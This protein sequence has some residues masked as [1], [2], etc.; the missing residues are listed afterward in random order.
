MKFNPFISSV[1]QKIIILSSILITSSTVIAIAQDNSPSIIVEE[2]ENQ[3]KRLKIDISVSD[4][5][6]IKVREGQVIKKGEVI[7]DKTQQRKQLELQLKNTKLALANI[8]NS[9]I[10]QPIEPQPVPPQQNLPS[11]NFV[12][13]ETTV[14]SA[15]L[16]YQQAQR[17]LSIALE[18]DP[19]IA[20]KGKIQRNQSKVE[21]GKREL[22]N[23]IEKTGIIGNLKNLPPEVLT[24]EQQKI[25]QKESELTQQQA[26]YDLVQAELN[27][28]KENRKLELQSLQ[29]KVST[30]RAKLELSQA[31]LQK[32]KNDRAL[33]E[34]N[35]SITV[36]RRIEEANQAQIAYN[37]QMQEYQ[38]QVRDKEFKVT[39]LTDSIGNIEDK[40]K[41]IAVV[42][43]PYSGTIRKIKYEKQVDNS[44]RVTITLSTV[45]NS[46]TGN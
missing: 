36:T 19:L 18:N 37:R 10:L 11:A 7:S 46:G 16:E 4:P 29:D 9:I 3:P 14:Q 8:K 38:Q 35:H 22:S 43:S 6:D 25:K 44:I 31:K 34:Y 13:E 39:Q 26:E 30:A 28:L 32:A 12:E 2:D 24:H 45:N 41:Q 5:L 1:F 17:T 33:L 42:T 15:E 21:Q 23:Q 20:V 27:Q 40:L